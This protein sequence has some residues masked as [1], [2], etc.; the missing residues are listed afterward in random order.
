MHVDSIDPETLRLII[1]TQL[2]DLQE[3][4][5]RNDPKGKGR[6]GGA[7]ANLN[8][9]LETYRAEL[10]ATEQLLKDQAMCRSMSLAAMR[11]GDAIRAAMAVDDQIVRDRRLA[12]E[13]SGRPMPRASPLL[14]RDPNLVPPHRVLDDA[15]LE[16]LKVLYVSGQD[17]DDEHSRQAESSAWAAS[18]PTNRQ[19]TAATT[20][21]CLACTEQIPIRDIT[22]CPCSHEYC[23]GCL[24]EHFTLALTDETLFPP[25]CC[26]QAIPIDSVRAL[27]SPT[28]V[29][30][31]MAK[32]IEFD[33]PNRTYCHRPTCST[34]IP[35]QFIRGDIALCVQ[36]REGT[37]TICKAASHVGADCPNDPS[38]QAILELAEQEGWQRCSTCRR[39]V[40]LNT[41]CNHISKCRT[42][43]AQLEDYALTSRSTA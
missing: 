38:T 14:P 30:Q 18:R 28:S 6:E 35:P 7:E 8:V 41:G 17:L 15:T 23:R 2:E 19:R 22:V 24:R 16:K 1:E 37:C 40:E 10:A 12:M 31:F 43:P 36:C 3:L 32:K 4:A 21:A 13:L 25:R 42:P 29:G 9:V 39:F 34:F 20:R 33:T 11:D 26:N 27:L 5:R